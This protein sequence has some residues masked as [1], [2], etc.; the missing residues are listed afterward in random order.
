[1]CCSLK[2]NLKISF[3]ITYLPYPA[4]LRLCLIETHTC[5]IMSQ[6]GYLLQHLLIVV[7]DWKH[8]HHKTAGDCLNKLG[9]F[10]QWNSARQSVGN[11][12]RCQYWMMSEIYCLKEN[13]RYRTMLHENTRYRTMLQDKYMLAG[14]KRRKGEYV[15]LG[16][17]IHQIT[18]ER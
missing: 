5:D 15:Y 9:S 2:S 8:P 3:T 18:I 12:P 6:P 10:L 13:A 14:Y 16:L 17:C 7:K 1:M 11:L 4:I